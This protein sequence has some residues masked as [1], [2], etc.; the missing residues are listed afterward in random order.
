MSN[1][2]RLSLPQLWAAC[3]LSLT[4]SGFSNK[5]IATLHF[6]HLSRGRNSEQHEQQIFF[7]L[8]AWISRCGSA[9]FDIQPA[10]Q[11]PLMHHRTKQRRQ[12]ALSQ[13]VI[14]FP[15]VP[16]YCS[17]PCRN[18]TVHYEQ[19]EITWQRSQELS[20]QYI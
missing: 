15:L 14:I 1:S 4:Y 10:V 13:T 9:Y 11:T 2:P 3:K 8:L 18:S 5:R 12:K 17:S 6:Q 20:S 16:E 19:E 7:P